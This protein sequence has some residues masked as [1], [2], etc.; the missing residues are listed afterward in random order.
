MYAE[1]AFAAFWNNNKNP[2]FVR[3]PFKP[4]SSYSIV[5]VDSNIFFHDNSPLNRVIITY[6]LERL[7]NGFN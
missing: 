6:F 2:L 7:N 3:I 4:E 1:C 5:A